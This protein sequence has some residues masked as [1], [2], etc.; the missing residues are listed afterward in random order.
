MIYKCFLKRL[1]ILTQYILLW[2]L[3]HKLNGYK[4]DARWYHKQGRPNWYDEQGI[5]KLEKEIFELETT[6]MME[7]G[8]I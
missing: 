1:L 8:D 3:K 2:I 6:I 4:R 7:R 5:P